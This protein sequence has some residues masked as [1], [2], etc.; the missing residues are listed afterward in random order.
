M[1]REEEIKQAAIDLAIQQ[2]TCTDAKYVKIGFVKGAEWADEHPRADIIG[3]DSISRVRS[4]LL[5]KFCK[6]AKEHPHKKYDEVPEMKE[7]FDLVDNFD[8][9]CEAAGF[10][11]N[12]ETGFYKIK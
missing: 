11:L 3:V 7:A 6:I 5:S 10:E 1:K 9:A 12:E 4:I 8:K 2:R